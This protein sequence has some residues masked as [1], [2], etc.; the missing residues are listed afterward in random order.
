MHGVIEKWARETPDHVAIYEVDTGRK[1]TYREFDAQSTAWALALLEMGFRPG[2]FLGTFLPL[3]AEHILLEYACFKIGVIHAPVD[4]R[5]K[6]PEVLRSLGLVK[7][8]GFVFPGTW[9]TSDFSDIGR[10]VKEQCPFV[11]HFIQVAPAAEAIDGAL[12]LATFV[13]NAHAAYQNALQDRER[14]SLWRTYQQVHDA[15][16]PTD[17][18]QVIYTTGSTGLP[19]PALLSHRNITSQNMCLAVGFELEG[20]SRMLVNL[21]PS[22]VG[23]QAEQLM[24]TFFTGGTAVILHVFDAEKTLKA[25]QDYASNRLGRFPR[26]STCSGSCPTTADYDLSS[27]KMV[28]FGGQQV[29]GRS[30]RRLAEAAL[31][32]GTGLGLTRNVGLCHVHGSDRQR[33]KPRQQRRLGDADHAADDSQTDERRRHG[34]RRLARRRNGRNLLQRPAGVHRLRQQPR[35]L[36]QNGLDATAF[37]TRATWDT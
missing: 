10:A 32:I 21:P 14:S 1:I 6:A 26:C 22:H 35:G 23:C 25:I 13:G 33:R 5:L 20:E 31:S 12:P 34:R 15:V 16:K 4:L 19:K 8:R 9:R 7:A 3:L 24:T 11:E 30:S 2:D 27:V 28:M 17:G 37:A 36:S 29:T 18:A